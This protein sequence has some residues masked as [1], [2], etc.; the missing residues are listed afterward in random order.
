LD[1]LMYLSDLTTDESVHFIQTI[2]QT[3]YSGT[4]L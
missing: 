4:V 2:P 1:Y 3:L